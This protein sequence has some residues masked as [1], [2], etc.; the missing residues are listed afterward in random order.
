M[1]MRGRRSG[2]VANSGQVILL[3]SVHSTIR[4]SLTSEEK[5]PV[6]L[7]RSNAVGEYLLAVKLWRRVRKQTNFKCRIDLQR[8]SA[9]LRL[10]SYRPGEEN[11][12]FRKLN[13]ADG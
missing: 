8:Y 7:K 6:T 3:Q 12:I 9:R 2:D 5:D 13:G 4:K 10:E 11:S 1:I